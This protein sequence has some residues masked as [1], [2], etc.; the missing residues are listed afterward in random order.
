MRMSDYSR[1]VEQGLV[2]ATHSQTI[3]ERRPRRRKSVLLPAVVT[4]AEGK[5]RFDCTI[6]DLS[7][8]GAR[9]AMPK[10]SLFAENFYLINIRDRMVCR[11]RLIWQME[12]EAGL[13][14]ETMV[15]LA[16]ITDPALTFL[17]RLWLE[18][19]IR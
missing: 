18:R 8:S 13:A 19:A 7:D 4:Q 2:Q 3:S 17:K 14:F 16:A 15:P 1:A 12:A 5:Q 9:I 11:A 10:G 6:R